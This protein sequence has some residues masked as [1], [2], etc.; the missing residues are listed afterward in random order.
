MKKTLV[1]LDAG[2]LLTHNEEEFD[3]CNRVYDKCLGYYN[4]TLAGYEYQHLN[5]VVDEAVRLLTSYDEMGYAIISNQG[6][7]DVKNDADKYLEQFA[8]DVED[9]IVYL[10]NIKGTIITLVNKTREFDAL[11]VVLHP[12]NHVDC[13]G[14]TEILAIP[15]ATSRGGLLRILV[16]EDDDKG[17]YIGAEDDRDL[18][19]VYPED[20]ETLLE[21]LLR[22]L[23][24]NLTKERNEKK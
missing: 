24:E 22:V 3:A 4:R 11:D 1:A 17:Y 7:C 8:F 10:I 2:T 19:E 9:I 18:D 21:V 14:P 16:G 6:V 12:Q 5:K 23:S 20:D 13:Y 15:N